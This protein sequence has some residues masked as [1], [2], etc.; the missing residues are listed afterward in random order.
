[1]PEKE[2]PRMTMLS[3]LSAM[4]DSAGHGVDTATEKGGNNHVKEIAV[5]GFWLKDKGIG[6]RMW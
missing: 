1:M 3:V 5:A 2:A 6:D 4:F